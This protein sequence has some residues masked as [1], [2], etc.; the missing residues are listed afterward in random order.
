MPYSD[1]DKAGLEFELE[2]LRKERSVLMQEVVELQQQQRT[3]LQRARQV[4]QRLQS[5][6]LIQKQKEIIKMV[7]T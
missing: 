1:A 3:T 6:E 7:I 5:A 4:N 2:S